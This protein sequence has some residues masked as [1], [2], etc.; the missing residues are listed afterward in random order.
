[1]FTKLTLIQK[2]VLRKR[3]FNDKYL[4]NICKFFFPLLFLLDS[5]KSNIFSEQ[6]I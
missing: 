4:Y 5:F 6:R 2:I 1:M 3:L